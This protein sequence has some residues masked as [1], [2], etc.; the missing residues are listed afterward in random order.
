VGHPVLGSW[1]RTK[2]LGIAA[3]L[4][5]GAGTGVISGVTPHAL[6]AEG[7]ITWTAG[8]V[9][10]VWQVAANWSTNTVPGPDDDVCINV[11]GANPVINNS[12]TINSLQLGATSDLDVNAPGDLTVTEAVTDFGPIRLN[13]ASLSS[14]SINVEDGSI[15][16][17]GRGTSTLSSPKLQ[18]INT[19]TLSSRQGTLALSSD[20]MNLAVETLSGGKYETAGTGA[21]KFQSNIS[22]LDAVMDIEGAGRTHILNSLGGDAL[23][24]LN[25]ITTRGDLTIGG[26]V[27]VTTTRSLDVQ[28]RVTLQGDGPTLAVSGPI[29]DERAFVSTSGNAR[30]QTPTFTLTQPAALLGPVTI[31]GDLVNSGSVVAGELTAPPGAPTHVTGNFT[32]KSDGL[33]TPSLLNNQLSILTV[34]GKAKLDGLLFFMAPGP[35]GTAYPVLTAKS[36]TGMF[37]QHSFGSPVTYTGT[38]AIVK[39][40][41]DIRTSATVT[42][43]QTAQVEGVGF[44]SSVKV[45]F[46][47]DK[48][49]GP[50]IGSVRTTSMGAFTAANISIPAGAKRTAHTLFAVA[51]PS[52]QRASQKITVN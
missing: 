10:D 39:V 2:S 51:K 50:G 15:I 21:I 14:P 43:G 36:R 3:G 31:Q 40:G 27:T 45:V 29:T 19:G 48:V 13:T 30:V 4:L 9:R 17:T 12:V 24:A 18:L 5:I 1:R 47:L 44:P 35:K 20:P 33:F 38:K 26:G 22:V 28:G 34:G 8:A 25:K 7:C 32:Q 16:S 37:A 49:A 6:A 23:R 52:G 11:D 42:H 41:P 46:Y